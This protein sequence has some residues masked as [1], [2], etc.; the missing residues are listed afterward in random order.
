MVNP[1]MLYELDP[2]GDVLLTIHNPNAPF[3][4]WHDNAETSQPSSPQEQSDAAFPTEALPYEIDLSLEPDPS[5]SISEFLLS[6]RHLVLASDYFKRIL[7]GP[8][9]EGI[10]APSDGRRHVDAEDWDEDAM[11]ILMQVIHGRNEKVPRSITLEMLGKI[12][13][14]VDYYQCHEAI[15]IWSDIWTNGYDVSLPATC[16]SDKER[17]LWILVAAVFG[18]ETLFQIATKVALEHCSEPLPTLGLPIMN[19]VEE[20]NQRRQD[21]I[22][23]VFDYLYSLL[24]LLRDVTVG[25]SFDCSS[26]M[27][28]ALTI[29][30][31]EQ[32]ILSPQLEPPY[33]GYSAT[34]VMNMIR[35]FSTPATAGGYR[36]RNSMHGCTL[37]KLFEKDLNFEIN[38]LSLSDI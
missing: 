33:L 19:V 20:F 10:S 8:W 27:L 21:L 32:G 9:K 1:N 23:R 35:N 36:T 24:G 5:P 2:E 14:L 34:S 37:S 11:L 16:E 25:C 12:A 6:S 22:Q 38:G 26:V 3:A 30:M 29:H 28:G 18:K 13:V 31:H 7:K 15:M 17:I 4:V